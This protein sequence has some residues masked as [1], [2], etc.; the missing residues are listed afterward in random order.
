VPIKPQHRNN[1]GSVI[2]G[3]LNGVKHMPQTIG[4]VI[5]VEPEILEEIIAGKIGLTENVEKALLSVP[6]INQRDFYFPDVQHL[7]PVI[8][9]TDNGVVVFRAQDT[10]KSRRT[11][12]RGPEKIPYYVYADTAMS[13]TSTFRP[14]WIKELYIHNGENADELP[15]WAFNKGHFEHQVTY[16]VGPVNFYW[17]DESGKRHVCRMNTGDTNCIVPFVPHTFTTRKEGEGLI[18]AVTYGGAITD[19]EFRSRISSLGMDEYLRY[20]RN[21]L[22]TL[23]SFV[24]KELAGGV[25]ICRYPDFIHPAHQPNTKAEELTVS[26]FV[27]EL[28]DSDRWGYNISNSDVVLRWGDN[29]VKLESGDSFFIKP[30]VTHSF[31]QMDMGHEGKLLIVDI[32]PQPGDLYVELALIEK[33]AGEAGLRRVHTETTRWY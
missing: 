20:V 19:P 14:E 3:L 10:F 18:L 23:P 13:N 29:S 30:G 6:G 25:N 21:N 1:V 7:F 12:T 28:K 4:P 26:E 24:V 9:D 2:R 31:V 15:D 32:K 33:Y 5:G 22:P 17:I 16:F 27:T 8:D 11:L